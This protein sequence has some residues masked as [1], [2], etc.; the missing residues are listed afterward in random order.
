MSERAGQ[1]AVE[2]VVRTHEDAVVDLYLLIGQK[3]RAGR[4]YRWWLDLRHYDDEII[5][6][7]LDE[8]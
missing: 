5:R 3:V 4:D 1:V 8:H 7:V 2:R 6:T